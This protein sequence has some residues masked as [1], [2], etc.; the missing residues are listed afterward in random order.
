MTAIS[1]ATSA[2]VLD[3]LGK[4]D[5]DFATMAD[6]FFEGEF[7]LWLGSGISFDRAPSLG[8]II[9]RAI[10]FLRARAIDPVTQA[11]FEPAFNEALKLSEI[12]LV[13][14]NPHLAATFAAWPQDI[15]DDIINILWN[16]YSELL[17]IRI[18]SEPED[19]ILWK[20]V[21]IRE[22]FEKPNSPGSV[23]LSIAILILEGALREIAS[24]NWDGFIEAA[25]ARLAGG[26]PGNLQVVVD[27]AHLRDAPGKARLLKFH[28]C[29]VH[30]TE[31]PDLYRQFLVGSE[32]QITNWPQSQFYAAMRNEVV[33]VATN[34]RALMTGLSLQDGNLQ[35][36]FS[37]ARQTNPW[38]WPCVPQAHVFCENEIV[39]GQ[40]KMLKTT[41]AGTYNDAIDEI[42]ASAHLKAWGEQVLLALVLRVVGA[43][44]S[45]LVRLVLATRPIA[46]E[47]NV[48]TD[49]LV[50]L[51][52]QVAALAIDD[53]TDF[54]EKAISVWSRL[55]S[56]FR[57]GFLPAAPN[58]YE[59]LSS[60][61]PRHL[62]DDQNA[63]AAAFGE[64]GIALALLQRGQ[65][66]GRW[67]LRLPDDANLSSGALSAIAS[68]DG[69]TART[70]FFART[71][72]V[73]IDLKKQ[74]AFANDNTIVIHA[75][76][77]W[78]Q[79]TQNSGSGS[80][81]TQSRAPGRIGSVETRHV[82]IAQILN[83]ETDVIGL[84]SQFVA[85]I[86]L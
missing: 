67:T 6:A 20:A 37:A 57:T 71:A 75:D 25:M 47:S 21:N 72:G 32:T 51:R 42:E 18:P 54:A 8:D 1:G 11:K 12:D 34:F 70:I 78:H 9:G 58:A 23:H 83:A 13:R 56:L 31:K 62:A 48:L 66:E 19:Y 45:E 24:A 61:S 40:R 38:N 77:A 60:G 84:H 76:D 74:G 53:R 16:K 52:D 46:A 33:S 10:E 26:L 82:S 3:M 35:A 2:T 28:G 29:I 69:A 50:A 22:A 43:K 65:N 73:A 14:V 80:A 41:Y 49:A 4:L 81:R 27:P 44:L 86:A 63:R 59:V 15:R 5:G 17:D 64:L 7:A 36:V 30:A 79:M 85:G 39:D 55:I 68:W